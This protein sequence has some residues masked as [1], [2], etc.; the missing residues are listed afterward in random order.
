[1]ITFEYLVTDRYLFADRKL[2][3]IAQ[4]LSH[5]NHTIK[6]QLLSPFKDQ[7]F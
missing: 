2:R 6:P 4:H 1:L 7:K 3:H 5:G